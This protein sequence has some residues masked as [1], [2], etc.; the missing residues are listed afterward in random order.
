MKNI[1][2]SIVNRTNY[3]KIKPVLLELKK[4]DNVKI[5]IVVSSSLLLDRYANAYKD[6]EKDFVISKK[7]NCLLSS[8]SLDSMV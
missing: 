2:V 6:I 7:I 3:S 4:S 1:A 5:N 8:D